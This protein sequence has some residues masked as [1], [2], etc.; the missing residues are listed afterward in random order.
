MGSLP[1]ARLHK[2]SQHGSY[3]CSAVLQE[4]SA[5]EWVPFG[6]TV[7][8]NKQTNKKLLLYH[9]LLCLDYS[10]CQTT[11]TSKDSLW[12]AASFRSHSPSPAGVLFGLQ[13][14][15][16]KTVY[17]KDVHDNTL[18]QRREWVYFLFFFFPQTSQIFAEDTKVLQ[19]IA[20]SAMQVP[21]QVVC[22]VQDL[23][24]TFYVAAL[25]ICLSKICRRTNWSASCHPWS[26]KGVPGPRLL[27]SAGHVLT[28]SWHTTYGHQSPT[29]STF[30]LFYI[31]TQ[32]DWKSLFPLWGNFHMKHECVRIFILIH[33][34]L[35]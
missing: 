12:A 20:S 31:K 2:L 35:I 4:W 18:S 33:E 34:R 9:G 22:N 13:G 24:L 6:T 23:K 11:C 14:E 30:R 17:R 8:E 32:V 28:A 3:L 16:S 15:I 26:R 21:Q 29:D 5:A 7:P 27:R 10:S 19:I 25:Q 1:L